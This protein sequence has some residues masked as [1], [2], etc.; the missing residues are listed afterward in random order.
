[1]APNPPVA[2]H[3][4]S[5]RLHLSRGQRAR[6]ASLFLLVGAL[7]LGEVLIGPHSS[8][9][10]RD[11]FSGIGAWGPLL[12]GAAYAALTCAMVPWPIL[13]GATGLLF[14]TALGTPVSLI[15]ATLGA[16]LAFLI[17][18]R[19]TRSAVPEFTT[20]RLRAWS[21]AIHSRG[22]LAVLYARI[23]P[24]APFAL[25][26]YAAGLTRVRFGDF[27]AATFIGAAPRAFAYTALGGNLGN[28][29]SP[30]AIA[31][32]AVLATMAVGGV[33]MAWLVRHRR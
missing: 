14:G 26:S 21:N 4:D 23:A 32:I 16:S 10:L 13:A 7:L 25:V 24:G 2:E 22:F 19:L 33:A 29:A 28:Y 3:A 12:V 8:R 15:S 6:L 17:S 27:A 1:M 11:A 18:R 9:Q 20:P 31:A 5:R 30:E